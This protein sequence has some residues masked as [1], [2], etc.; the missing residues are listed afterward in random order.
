MN[1]IKCDIMATSKYKEPPEYLDKI[2]NKI[3]DAAFQVHKRWGP[4]LLEQFYQKALF[5]ELKKYGF[6]VQSEV[7]LPVDIGGTIVDTAYKIDLL[8]ENEIII[9]LKSVEELKPVHYQQIRTYLKIGNKQLGYLINFNTPLIM[10]GIKRQVMS[11]R[12]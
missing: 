1:N 5:I 2:G 10:E 11:P 4:G 7:Y 9:E 3:V 12:E 8:V 6:D